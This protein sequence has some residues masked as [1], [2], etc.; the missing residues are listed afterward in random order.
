MQADSIVAPTEAASPLSSAI[1]VKCCV[2]AVEPAPQAAYTHMIT[3]RD[4]TIGIAFPAFVSAVLETA[5]SPSGFSPFTVGSMDGIRK[6][7]GRFMTTIS[8]AFI[9]YAVLHPLLWITEE[10]I[11]ENTAPARPLKPI[12]I[13]VARPTLE[14]NQLL[15]TIVTNT[16]PRIPDANPRSAFSIY[17]TIIELVVE[18]RAVLP[19]ITAVP[20]IRP[21]FKVFSDMN[22]GDISPPTANSRLLIVTV[23]LT[24]PLSNPSSAAIGLK[25]SPATFVI[26]P[27]PEA[28]SPQS[29]ASIIKYL[30]F[31]LLTPLLYGFSINSGIKHIKYLV[32]MCFP[33]PESMI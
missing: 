7:A 22:F 3:S 24:A 12:A 28:I 2:R 23:I 6:I 31:K 26:R 13:E 33:C 14:W 19:A 8:A 17:M 4:M 29:D 9:R 32:I 10:T 25:N 1:P 15:M 20:M 11:G 30:P 16:N 18:S 27:T 21:G 5:F